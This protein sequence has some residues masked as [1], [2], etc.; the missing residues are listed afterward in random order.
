MSFVFDVQRM[1]Q[2]IQMNYGWSASSVSLTEH[3]VVNR[4]SHTGHRSEGV[5]CFFSNTW[6]TTVCHLT[7]GARWTAVYSV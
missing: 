3:A 7:A 6:Y 1:I 2:I 4:E 5:F